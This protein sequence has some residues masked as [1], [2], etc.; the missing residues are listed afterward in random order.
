MYRLKRIL[1]LQ[2][3][4]PGSSVSDTM[5]HNHVWLMKMHTNSHSA[6]I[7]NSIAH[8]AVPTHVCHTYLPGQPD[9]VQVSYRLHVRHD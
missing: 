5:P 2:A 3:E 7:T 6:Y 8:T 4:P 9:A 1:W